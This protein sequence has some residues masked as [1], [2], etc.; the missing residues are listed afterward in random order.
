MVSVGG[1]RR[2]A[3]HYTARVVGL[4]GRP[5]ASPVHHEVDLSSAPARADRLL[6]ELRRAWPPGRV[7]PR[8]GFL[9]R[10]VEQDG[11]PAPPWR[12][13]AQ[14]RVTWF[15]AALASAG[16]DRAH[17]DAAARGARLLREQLW[18][19]EHGGFVF[20][21]DPDDVATDGSKHLY[22]HAFGLFAIAQWAKGPGGEEA[23][24]FANEI[25]DVIEQRWSPSDR[26]GRPEVLTREWSPPDGP[27]G[28][29]LDA[30]LHLLE[31]CTLLA[32]VTTRPTVHATV[33]DLVSLLGDELVRASPCGAC[34]DGFGPGWR[35][36]PA[37]RH[38]VSYGHECERISLVLRAVDVLGDDPRPWLDRFSDLVEHL[39][40]EAFDGRLGGLW[41]SGP[42]CRPAWH[43]QK[44]WWVQ[45]EALYAFHS[46]HGRR[47]DPT[48]A[49]LLESTLG[50]V[51]AHQHDPIT[52]DWHAEVRGTR[53]VDRPIAG[54]WKAPY[55]A[56]RA[57]LALTDQLR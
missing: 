30:H 55:H 14:A 27:W 3:V 37:T 28:Q 23:L 39:A 40:R 31:A 44:V 17:A 21:R 8:G 41:A 24:R 52:G 50:W 7:D 6:T 29:T 35:P 57:L 53:P 38:A 10:P 5:H 33:A 51:E 20:E 19:A 15:H 9:V 43:R 36:R 2:A 25:F 49:H 34:L 47:P 26:R 45:A 12:T 11:E 13:I 54:P 16:H 4:A 56:G 42:P 46:L 32:E 1:A 22:T 48:T 18:D